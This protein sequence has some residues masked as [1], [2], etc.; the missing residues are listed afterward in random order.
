M[1]TPA[2]GGRRVVAFAAIA[3]A[4]AVGA[5]AVV[6]LVSRATTEP[7]GDWA[8]FGNTS[9]NTRFSPAD[10]VDA[11]NVGRL[12]VAWERDQGRGAST[13][14]TFPVVVGR[15]MYVSTN[16][17]AVLALDA[18]TGKVLWRYVPKVDLLFRLSR[19]GAS[20]PANRGVAVAGG[21]VYELTF[22]CYLIALDP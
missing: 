11:S 8:L 3:V 6:A 21:R 7:D 13:W 4:L 10:Q 19:A 20:L 16:T 18:A 12:P 17:N 1:R 14:E 9:D 22:D 15:R 5:A 2:P